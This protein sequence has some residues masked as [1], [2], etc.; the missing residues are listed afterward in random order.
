MDRWFVID[1]AVKSSSLL[2]EELSERLGVPEGPRLLRVLLE[3]HAEARDLSREPLLEPGCS[4]YI[5]WIGAALFGVLW[6]VSNPIVGVWVVAFGIGGL[7]RHVRSHEKRMADLRL[8]RSRWSVRCRT[9]EGLISEMMA[10]RAYLPAAVDTLMEAMQTVTVTYDF[11]R[12]CA[13]VGL[14]HSLPMVDATNGDVPRITLLKLNALLSHSDPALTLAALVAV[15]EV[16]DESSLK[17][18]E[19]LA[20]PGVFTRFDPAVI[21]AAQSALEKLRARLGPAQEAARLLRPSDGPG[22]DNL[23]RPAACAAHAPEALLRAAPENKEP[24]S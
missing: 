15:A 8:E 6:T 13:R 14:L 19:K 1:E 11:G 4:A 23:L 5:A 2:R 21:P 12:H 20:S 22:D 16:G 7:V 18:M 24:T 10:Q 3:M 17:H 9:L